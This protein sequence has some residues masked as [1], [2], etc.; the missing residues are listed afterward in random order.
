MNKA[1]FPE[2]EF[3]VG[4]HKFPPIISSKDLNL[5]LKLSADKIKK[6]N[7]FFKDLGFFL[8][9][10]DPTHTSAIINK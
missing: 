1:F 3:H 10:K 8:Q 7:K 9:E 6:G 4:G 5:F 2:K